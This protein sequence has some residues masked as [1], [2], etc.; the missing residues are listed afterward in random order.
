MPMPLILRLS[1][2]RN[3][4][5]RLILVLLLAGAVHAGGQPPSAYDAGQQAFLARNFGVAAQRFEEAESQAGSASD[6][7]LF[8]AKSLLHLNR[9]SDAEAALKRYLEAHPK[10]S[11]ASFLRGFVLFR[12]DRAA[13]S[14]EAYTH[15]AT[16]AM[17]H[18]DDL[19]IVALDYVL[20][21]DDA[22]AV[23]WLERSL[24]MNGSDP[25][26]WYFLGRALFSQSRFAEAEHGFL[27]ALRLDPAQLR[28]RNNLGLTYEAEN[29]PADALRE[30]QEAVARDRAARSGTAAVAGKPPPAAETEAQPYVN[31]GSLLILQNRSA[32]AV[33]I[34]QESAAISVS[35]VP[36][37][38]QLGRALGREGKLAAA[39]VELEVA[40]KLK[41]ED[42]AL[43]YELGLLYQR[44][45]DKAAAK[46]ELARSKELYGNRAAGPAVP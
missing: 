21:H 23:R 10:N 5:A 17:P 20:L 12:E 27:E 31:L 1:A 15:A 46:V 41:P 26:A 13:P 18:A 8:L 28:A 6:A 29:R 19:K 39:R 9:F 24:Q 34:L 30:Y 16:L 36:C 42:P 32:E 3:L 45:G 38:L 7:S 14:L 43:H 11:E 33:P 35:C 4:S 40:V 2:R 44:S 25:E 37:H 22:S